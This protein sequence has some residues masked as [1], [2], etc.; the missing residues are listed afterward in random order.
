M[1]QKLFVLLSLCTL[2]STPTLT[3]GQGKKPA[4]PGDSSQQTLTSSPNEP[5]AANWS[6]EKSAFYLDT[7]SLAW[8]AR[9]R[10]T[11]CHTGYLHLMAGPSLGEKPSAAQSKLRQFMENR[12]AHWD[13]GKAPDRPGQ[14][15]AIK[16]L[17][18]EGT[19][20]IVATATALA[21]HDAGTSGHLHPRTRQALDRIWTLQ[22][23]NGA[24]TW[25]KSGL[26]PLEYDDYFGAVFAALGLGVAPD[27]Y[28]RTP[29]AQQG[30]AR[31]RVYFQ[32]NPPPNLHH[33]LWLLWA[34]VKLDVLA[35]LAHREETIRE[36]RGLQQL[37]GGW[38]LP[39]LWA[40]RKT[41]APAKRMESDGYAT[42]LSIYA[43]RQAGLPAD[44]PGIVRGLA[45]LKAHQR[46]SGRWFTPSLNGSSRNLITN[47]GT[48]LCA[49]AL[50]A[51][52]KGKE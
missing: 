29:Q 32:H 35:P 10:C 30:L 15:S 14:G 2:L 46:Q 52:A 6:A 51:C 43:L 23:P 1:R 38:S 21:F 33:Q 37:D 16:P 19:T 17:P 11:A 9:W 13:S 24:W 44:D 4:P 12:V 26:A 48:A 8:L 39:T 36:L 27:G 41:S 18:T 20:E 31:L 42:G 49:M 50:Q 45:W 7:V 34:S 28:V 40:D 5:L 3:Y 47:A 22:Q 25:N